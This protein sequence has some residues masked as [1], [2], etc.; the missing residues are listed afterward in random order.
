MGDASSIEWTDATWNPTRGCSRVDD[1]GCKNC[2][3]M[4]FAH[5]F[6]GP[7]QRY[8][9]LTILRPK[10]ASRPGVD[11]SGKVQLVPEQLELPLG[12]RKPR[13][14]FVDSMSDLFHEGLPDEALDAVIAV[15]GACDDA[16]L[17]HEF[18]VLTKRPARAL[19]YLKSERARKAWNS[20]RMNRSAW[21][22]RNLWLGVSVSN[23]KNADERIPLLLQCP[24]AIRFVSY[25]PA[26][27]P[28]DFTHLDAEAAGHKDFCVIDALTGRQ[29][30]MGR[31]CP[32]VGAKLDWIIVGGESGH[33]ARPFDVWW[34]VQTI[35]Q[36]KAA[37]VACF[38][39][40]VGSKPVIPVTDPEATNYGERLPWPVKHPKGGDWDE[41]PRGLREDLRVR[42][43]PEVRS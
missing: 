16:G 37:G 9:G 24:A 33:G 11:W 25:E 15:M 21:P 5:R 27:G 40:Q 3:A 18:Q 14:V 8:E 17:G 31:P 32:D 19:G 35:A 29:T 43:F 4:R 12:W 30:D 7:G 42:Q 38:V 41:W 6:S 36:C 2:Y 28:V 1:D 34:A 10:T 39:K 20:R 13:K 22:A 26:L 23:Q